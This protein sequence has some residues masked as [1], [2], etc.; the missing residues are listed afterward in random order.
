MQRNCIQTVKDSM[1][2]N[3]QLIWVYLKYLPWWRWFYPYFCL[4]F[5]CFHTIFC[6]F[7]I[8]SWVFWLCDRP[9]FKVF[10]TKICQHIYI[11][12]DF[13]SQNTYNKANFKSQN[14][15]NKA[16]FKTQ[17]IYIRPTFWLLNKLKSKIFFN[18]KRSLN[19]RHFF[20]LLFSKK[21]LPGS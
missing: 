2:W 20:G 8:P 7:S 4:T 12:A 5:S 11:K 13:K 1:E 9:F 21:N 15:Y 17:N 18:T 16:N 19:F 10:K 6:N 14:I 3:W